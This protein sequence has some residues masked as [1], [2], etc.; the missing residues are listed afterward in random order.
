VILLAGIAL[1]VFGMPLVLVM[2]AGA[3]ELVSMIYHLCRALYL[4]I[5]HTRIR[6]VQHEPATPKSTTSKTKKTTPTDPELQKIRGMAKA[7]KGQGQRVGLVNLDT[8]EVYEPASVSEQ[9]G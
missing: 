4:L 9:G 6:R 5:R 3:V 2:V 1:L 8:G 7:W